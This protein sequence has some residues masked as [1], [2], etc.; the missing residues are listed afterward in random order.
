MSHYFLA[1]NFF[2]I[3]TNKIKISL[4]CGESIKNET[5]NFDLNCILGYK[6]IEDCGRKKNV[7]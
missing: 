6:I 1:F 7:C 4:K 3:K 5:I 2:E